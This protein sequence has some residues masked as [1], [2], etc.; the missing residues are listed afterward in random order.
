LTILPVDEKID[1]SIPPRITLDD[2]K[3]RGKTELVSVVLPLKSMTAKDAAPEIKRMMGALGEI[4]VL[5]NNQLV[6]QDTVGNL[7][8]VVAALDAV[9]KDKKDPAAP[10]R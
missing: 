5:S 9:E 2:L 3:D 10:D 1:P 4:T 7:R 6:V 8:R